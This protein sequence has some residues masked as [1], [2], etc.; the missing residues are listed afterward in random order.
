MTMLNA[1]DSINRSTLNGEQAW[2][3]CFRAGLTYATN[4]IKDT[5]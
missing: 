3:T 4:N 5:L 1:F 2:K